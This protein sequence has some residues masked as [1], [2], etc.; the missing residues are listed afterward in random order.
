MAIKKVPLDIRFWTKVDKRGANDCWGWTAYL[1]PQGYGGI[2]DSG[3][4][5]LAHRMAW[6]LVYRE[7]PDGLCV[8]HKC[9]NPPCCNPSHLF[10]GTQA[11]NLTDRDRKGRVAHGDSHTRTVIPDS[12]VSGIRASVETNTAIARRFGVSSDHIYRIKSGRKRR[13]A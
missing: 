1:T 12:E 13:S 3:R 9:D 10:L 8:L 4:T 6:T 7:I 5:L 2:R 11:D